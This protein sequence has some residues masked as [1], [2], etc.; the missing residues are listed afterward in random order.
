MRII[1]LGSLNIDR[2]YTVESFAR[3]SE[4]V[5]A[6][7]MET[8]LGG[9]GFNQSLALAR[10]GAQVLHVGAVGQ[11]G[12][13]LRDMLQ[14]EGVD[15]TGILTSPGPSGHTVIQV[16]SDHHH[17]VLITAGANAQ[18]TPIMIDAALLQCQPGDWFL[19]QNETSCVAYGMEQAKAAGLRVAFNPWPMN[20]ALREYPL[21]LVDLFML[22]LAGGASLGGLAP[23]ADPETVLDKLSEIYPKAVI[24]LALGEKGA[25]CAANGEKAW[26]ELYPV[27]VVDNVAA[28]DTFCGFFLW[29]YDAGGPL[30]EV[31]RLASA[32][33]ALA[34][35]R[36]E[37]RPFIPTLAEVQA[38]M[39]EG[40]SANE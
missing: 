27:K 13:G 40:C 21:E 34:A 30:E 31:L 3:E 10:A 11:D 15:V 6:Q 37:A 32:A 14:A 22:H 19:T 35:S 33:A 28:V 17:C 4:P 16:N 12:G 23:N 25:L 24:A 38:F 26:Q 1:N 9:K 5:S 36:S 7:S 39:K 2:V 8:V 18:I 29:A 20:K